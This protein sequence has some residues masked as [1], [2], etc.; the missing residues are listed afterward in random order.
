M[1]VKPGYGAG[2][3][4]G[5]QSVL[6][7]GVAA[8]AFIFSIEDVLGQRDRPAVGTESGGREQDEQRLWVG[9]VC[10]PTLTVSVSL[11]M[12]FRRWQCTP[13]WPEAAMK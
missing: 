3:E 8:V 12:C 13:L 9:F 1:Q 6:L 4:P 10:L 11:P 2:T 5:T 7:V